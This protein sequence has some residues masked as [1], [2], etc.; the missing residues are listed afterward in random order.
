MLVFGIRPDVLYGCSTSSWIQQKT[1]PQPKIGCRGVG[2]IRGSTLLRGAYA[3]P[4][5]WL[6][7]KHSAREVRNGNHP[8]AAYDASLRWGSAGRLTGASS[9]GAE[10][11]GF[12]E[13]VLSGELLPTYFS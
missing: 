3:A 1:P 9:V 7:L 12:S 2:S 13:T 11:T 10:R 6:A 5:Q 8:D 4:P